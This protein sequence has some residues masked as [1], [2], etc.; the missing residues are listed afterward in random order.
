VLNADDRSRAVDTRL[1]WS[2]RDDLELTL[3]ALRFAGS[4]ASEYGR[5]PDGA[6]A[7]LKWFF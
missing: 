7:A 6:F 3:G 5:L 2:W 1:V 4:T